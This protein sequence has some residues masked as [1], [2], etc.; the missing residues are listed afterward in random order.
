MNVPKLRFP[1][2]KNDWEEERLRKYF[3]NY[4]SPKSYRGFACMN[5]FI[6]I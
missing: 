1:E 4:I 5:L 6:L 2:F 3:R